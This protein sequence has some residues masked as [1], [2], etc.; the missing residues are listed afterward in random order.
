MRMSVLTILAGMMGGVSISTGESSVVTQ[1]DVFTGGRNGYHTYRIPALVVTTKG[2]VLAFC[3]GRK[4]NAKDY[5]DIDLLLKRSHDGGR[6]W[7]EQVVLYEEGKGADITIGN[8]CPIVDKQGVIHLLFTRD[9][10]RLFYTKSMDDGQTWSKPQEHTGILSG[11]AYPLI[12]IATGPVHGISLRSGRLVATVWVSDRERKDKPKGGDV[13]KNRYQSGVIY[14]DDNGRTWKT[15]GLVRPELHN[16][17][18]CTVFE[19]MDGTLYLNMRSQNSG[20][21]AVSESKDGG[22]S[23]TLPVLDRNLPCPTCQGSILRVT[24]HGV[25]FANP[26]SSSR[27]K[28]TVRYSNDEAKTWGNAR[29][30]EAG[31]SGYSDL[32]MTQ[33]GYVLC[34]FECGNKV[35]N[36]KITIARFPLAWIAAE[37]ARV[38]SPASKP[39]GQ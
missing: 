7:S 14:S 35:Y 23:W 4:N 19:R 27:T 39:S 15:G 37:P 5:G 6:S 26:A 33:D 24:D 30:L 11:F 29:V 8:P 34:L 12:R 21:R 31:P 9:N 2:T 16:L 22:N 3:E 18:E 28:M 13:A 36:E 20:Y 25:V 1:V 32:A 38:S 10:K 17:N